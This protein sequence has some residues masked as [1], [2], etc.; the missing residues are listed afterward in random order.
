MEKKISWIDI[1]R[2]VLAL[3]M[4]LLGGAGAQTLL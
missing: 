2:A 4:G 3:V 1:V